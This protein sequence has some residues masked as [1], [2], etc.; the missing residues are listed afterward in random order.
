MSSLRRR[1]VTLPLL[2]TA[3]AL[4]WLAAPVLLAGAALVDLVR[5]RRAIA[6]RLTAFGLA[7]LALESLGVLAAGLTWLWPSRGARF[8]ERSYALQRAWSGAMFRAAS[9]ALSLR[10]E[11]EGTDALDGGPF[12]L[13]MRHASLIDTVLPSVLV[14]NPRRRR[15]RYVL[16]REL[17]WDPCLDLVGNRLP[18]HFVDRADVREEDLA[19]I[20][21]LGVG[22]RP[23]DG[24]MLYP[25]GTF[26]TE[27]RRARE[28]ARMKE[29][30]SKYYDRARALERT[31]PPR[32]GGLDA[33]LSAA[34]AL[35][36]VVCAHRGLGGFARLPDIARGGVVGATIEVRFWRVRRADIPDG[37]EARQAWLYE[38]WEAVDR[39][40]R[41]ELAREPVR[42]GVSASAPEAAS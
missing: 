13:L 10:V 9:R 29:R 2:A 18:N 41:G 39:F 20:G 5:P 36:V 28:L 16:K 31:L 8:L 1:S 37:R 30:G 32:V 23:G 7:Y 4:G 25:E 12:V 42:A 27:A 19:A 40:A 17:L 26:F 6:S 24:V 35:D 33:I 34:P 22:L 11:V 15:L 21:A 3:S 38:Q 14:A